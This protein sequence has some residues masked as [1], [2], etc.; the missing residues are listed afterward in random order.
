MFTH[1]TRTASNA[2]ALTTAEEA[3]ISNCELQLTIE[4]LLNWEDTAKTAKAKGRSILVKFPTSLNVPAEALENCVKLCA[5]VGCGTLVMHQPMFREYGPQLAELAPTLN[6]AVENNRQSKARFIEWA[7]TH[8]SLT[9][10]IEHFWK[11]TL[12]DCDQE[13]L[14]VETAAFLRKYGYK[15][16]AV[17]MTGYQPGEDVHRPLYM[18]REATLALLSILAEVEFG[19][20]VVGETAEDL[21]THR[22]L[23]MD[24]QLVASWKSQSAP[25]GV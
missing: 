6:L 18:N 19:G 3:G 23:A 24:V 9:F 7:E 10:D 5:V 8:S 15:V 16:K 20:F 14:L 12:G 22:E 11:F 21:R 25:V 13:T 17:H 1:A 2:D 4:D